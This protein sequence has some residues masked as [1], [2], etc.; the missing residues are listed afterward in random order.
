MFQSFSVSSFSPVKMPFER[1]ILALAL[2]VL[3][4]CFQTGRIFR[5][6]L[7]GTSKVYKIRMITYTTAWGYYCDIISFYFE[8][9]ISV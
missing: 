1:N 2:V 6:I 3:A 4:I 8:P 7:V 9:K 5:Q